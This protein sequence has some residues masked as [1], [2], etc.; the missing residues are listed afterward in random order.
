MSGVDVG[1]QREGCEERVD[2]KWMNDDTDDADADAG[3]HSAYREQ[4]VVVVGVDGVTDGV[5]AQ[6]NES[7]KSMLIQLSPDEQDDRNRPEDSRRR[8]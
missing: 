6:Q 2:E 8:I 3:P 7:E 1:M 4:S 5:G